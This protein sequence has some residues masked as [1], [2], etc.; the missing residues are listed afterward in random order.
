MN[1]IIHSIGKM[2]SKS[3]F[4]QD[5]LLK[6][7]N[8]C[9]RI[10]YYHLV[11]DEIPDYYFKDKAISTNDFKNQL[12]H[13]RKNFKFI[14]LHEAL[15]RMTE[16]K[17]L[18]GYVS[19]TTDDGFVENYSI[20][21]P[22]LMEEGIPATFFLI[23]NCIDNKDLM[24]R[25]KLVYVYNT[26]GE[27]RSNELISEIALDEKLPFPGK[28]ENIIS[29]SKR[30]FEM[31]HKDRLSSALWGKAGFENI[32]D[33]LK[34]EKPYLN[35]NQIKELYAQEFSIGSHSNSHPICSRLNYDDLESEVIGS[36]IGI[37][38]K[39]GIPVNLFS[40]PFEERAE[41]KLEKQLIRNHK[42]RVKALIGI[43]NVLKNEDP[44]LWERDL[45]ETDSDQA[46]FRFYF[47]PI[48]RR[49]IRFGKA[50]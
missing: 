47:L 36:M 33:F 23:N 1:L 6:A 29:W 32:Q 27:K 39:T 46:M 49:A 48:I 15:N 2:I 38:N 11:S 22:I 26:L 10:L 19:L 16:G 50:S 4:L 20:I 30:T 13:Y 18:K 25:N 42:D 8:H 17:S 14:S 44:Y 3:N 34:R 40:Y 7:G 35:I 9:F 45:Q 41:A 12:H 37:S 21:A 5:I 24:W 43:R 28:G 31:N